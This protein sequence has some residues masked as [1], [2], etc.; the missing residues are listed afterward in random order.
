MGERRLRG[1]LVEVRH[2][3]ERGGPTHPSPARVHSRLVKIG[4]NPYT[5]RYRFKLATDLVEFELR[6][7]PATLQNLDPLP[8]AAPDW[9]LLSCERCPNCPLDPLRN[10]RCPA[11][12]RLAPVVADFAHTLSFTDAEVTVSVPERQFVKNTTVQSGLSSLMGAYLATSGCPVLGFLRPM[13]RL[14]LPFSSGLETLLRSTSFYLLRQ[15][16][17]SRERLST[18]WSL[19]GLAEHYREVATVNKAFAAR[20][21]EAA[22]Q[23]ANVNAL[24][25]LDVFAKAMPYSIEDGLE[26]FRRYFSEP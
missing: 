1:T 15:Y 9:T 3:L 7:D 26:E 20:L 25:I 2:R 21:R 18:D 16:F 22:P 14:H 24:V 19:A 4:A 6:L 5:I 13:A 17:R 8:A 10:E 11:A 12:A 23:D